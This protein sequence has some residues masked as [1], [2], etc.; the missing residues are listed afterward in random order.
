MRPENRNRC[1]A[2]STA[3]P[4][5]QAQKEVFVNETVARLDALVHLAIESER[6]DPP[7]TPVD[8]QA[9]LIGTGA[10]GEWAGRTGQI[11]ARQGGN[12][13]FFVARDGLRA[14]N[15]ATGQDLRYRNGWIAAAKPAAPSGGT[16]IDA[17]ARATLAQILTA[18]SSAGI[19]A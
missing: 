13:Q 5:G 12:W 19:T 7:A 16:T 17:E 11:A 9:W 3:T 10:S 14:L 6:P 2:R 4:A 15:R 8:G 1:A 18:L